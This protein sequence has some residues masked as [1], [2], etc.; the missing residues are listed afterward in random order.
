M[1]APRSRSTH[2]AQVSRWR[3]LR[4]LIGAPGVTL[5][6]IRVFVA[7]C[8]LIDDVGSPA[9]IRQRDLAVMVRRSPKSVLRALHALRSRGLVRSE[10]VE[11]GG[12]NR[13]SI[14]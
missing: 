3:R 12:V 6:E 13:Y 5:V 2:P 9:E 10:A 4:D 7:L 14:A 11:I 8:E 1:S